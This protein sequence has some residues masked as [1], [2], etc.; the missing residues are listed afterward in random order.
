MLDIKP[1]KLVIADKHTMLRRG[2]A[3]SIENCADMELIGE[4]GTAKELTELCAQLRPDVVL[5][6]ISLPDMDGEQ[7]LRIIRRHSPRSRVLV[8]TSFVSEGMVKMAV[9]AGAVGYLHKS[10]E[11]EALVQAIRD[12]YNGKATLSRDAEQAL[13]QALQQPILTPQLLTGREREVLS[14]M[15]R[16]FTNAQIA[17]HLTI[18]ILTVK[19]H[20]SSIFTKLQTSNRRQAVALAVQH[21]LTTDWYA[22]R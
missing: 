21:R 12:A 11:C 13:V 8:L 4:A 16:G 20:V 15:A 22:Q 7:V 9:S 17:E 1:I 6:D 3:A 10:I 2:L 19:K 18:S 5:M 14:L